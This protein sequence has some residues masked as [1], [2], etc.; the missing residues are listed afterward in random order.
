MTYGQARNAAQSAERP[1]R[2]QWQAMAGCR[3]ADLAIAELNLTDT[4]GRVETLHGYLSADCN[5]FRYRAHWVL[6]Y[7]I[8]AKTGLP[9]ES[10]LI[11][12]MYS[13]LS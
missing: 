13:F 6:M 8:F 4:L 3:S 9:R 7:L 12:S 10:A 11:R 1:F 5:R 2:P